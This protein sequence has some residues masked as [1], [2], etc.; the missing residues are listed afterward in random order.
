M[1]TRLWCMRTLCMSSVGLL[2]GTVSTTL[3]SLI[4]R[5]VSGAELHSFN[6]IYVQVL[7]PVTLQLSLKTKPVPLLCMFSAVR[8]IRTTNWTICGDLI[9]ALKSGS[10]LSQTTVY[11]KTCRWGAVVTQRR[12][13]TTTSSSSVASTKSP[14]SWMIALFLT[15]RLGCGQRFAH[16]LLKAIFRTPR[17]QR[18]RDERGK[19]CRLALLGQ[20]KSQIASKELRL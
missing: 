19:I 16:L 10:V 8:T 6:K 18:T 13:I 4:L 9:W 20:L 14:R 17:T 2:K 7:E 1:S 12:S 3:T 5:L 11:S 15:S